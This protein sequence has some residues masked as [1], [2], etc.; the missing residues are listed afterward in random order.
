ML[1]WPKRLSST[2]NVLGRLCRLLTLYLPVY[3]EDLRSSGEMFHS[4]ELICCFTYEKVV[5]TDM[6]SPESHPRV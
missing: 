2:E 5:Y 1:V 6:S 3:I 4:S